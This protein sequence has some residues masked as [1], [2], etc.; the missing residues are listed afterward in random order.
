MAKRT[1]AG[2]EVRIGWNYLKAYRNSSKTEQICR[3]VLRNAGDKK[4]KRAETSRDLHFLYF[5]FVL[6]VCFGTL[7]SRCQHPWECVKCEHYWQP[8]Q[9]A[10]TGTAK[11]YSH[12][13]K[14]T[15]CSHL[16]LWIDGCP[17]VTE[18]KL[19]RGNSAPSACRIYCRDC[20]E[21]RAVL[22]S[23][24]WGVMRLFIPSISKTSKW[25]GGPLWCTGLLAPF[26]LE[27]HSVVNKY[28]MKG[29]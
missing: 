28:K 26:Q 7:L 25:V 15:L 22:G 27:T 1:A 6:F 24:S 5:F 11:R 8:R 16:F 2:A 13:Q 29:V 17:P 3:Y 18:V 19:W 12:L 20:A 21:Q 4:K 14:T 23:V 9:W 10:E